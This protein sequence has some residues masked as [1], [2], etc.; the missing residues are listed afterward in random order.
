M[1]NVL[2][3][4]NIEPATGPEVLLLSLKRGPFLDVTAFCEV[5]AICLVGASWT[6]QQIVS[7][8]L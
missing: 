7:E 1:I 5:G 3:I 2:S 6:N 8:S 4:Q